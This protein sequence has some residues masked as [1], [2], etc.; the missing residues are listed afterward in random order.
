M[1]IV[2]DNTP[3]IGNPAVHGGSINCRICDRADLE[4]VL[5]LGP[6][7]WANDFLTPD[8]VG[9]EEKYPLQ[10]YWCADCNAAQLG[11][12]VPKE[13]MFSDHTYAS[14]TTE[15]LRRHFADTARYVVDR[16]GGKSVLDI[17][18]NDGTCL[19]EYKKLGLEVQGVE[20][21]YRLAEIAQQQN[22]IPTIPAFF[23]LPLAQSLDQYDI[24][25]LSGVFFHLEEL[26]S[27]TEGVTNCLA[28]QGVVIIQFMYMP[29]IM[30]NAAFDCIY[31]EHLLYYTVKTCQEILRRHGLTIIDGKA[32]LIHGGSMIVFA[33]HYS[34][35]DASAID[36][37]IRHEDNSLAA[38]MDFAKR[39]NASRER[40]KG[41][42]SLAFQKNLCIYGLGAPVKG[43]TLLNS[44]GITLREISCLVERNPMRRGL[45]APGSHI[46]VIMEDEMRFRP[47]V[48]LVLAWNF[49]EEIEK[50]YAKDRE[51][52]IEFFYPITGEG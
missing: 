47:D 3:T 41:K 26:H 1:K 7:P 30:R 43:N 50:R 31:H 2:V 42:I 4:F 13:I 20:S 9:K 39:A 15:T 40:I 11:Y 51:A 12:T 18:S 45:I 32:A 44:C 14:G 21:C 16:F 17:G 34:A 28:P 24:I 36:A 5:D 10:L 25:N 27:F 48:W 33:K 37:V 6:Q 49:R 8:R 35:Q 52:G 29:E 23:N 19:R 38:Y 46:P 22:G